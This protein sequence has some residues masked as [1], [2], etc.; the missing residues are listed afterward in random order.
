MKTRRSVITAP[1]RDPRKDPRPG[2]VLRLPGGD[3]VTVSHL[4]SE[5]TYQGSRAMVGYSDN[6]YMR[7]SELYD[8]EVLHAAD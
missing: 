2:D 8:A 1:L 3:E 6:S 7:V 4:C 5:P